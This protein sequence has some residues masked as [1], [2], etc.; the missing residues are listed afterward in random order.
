[1]AIAKTTTFKIVADYGNG[2]VE[3]TETLAKI[4]VYGTGTPSTPSAGEGR[5]GFSK[6]PSIFKAK[7]EVFDLEGTLDRVFNELGDLILDNQVQGIQ[8]LEISVGQVMDYRKLMTAF[9]LIKLP[10]KID[11]TAT[12]TVNEQFIRLEYQGLVKGFQIF[13]GA[14][15]NLLSNRDVKADVLLKLIFEFSSPVQPNGAEISNIKQA[16]NRNPVDR[17]NLT[18]KVTY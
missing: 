6:T 13:Q 11:Q 17:V 5:E 18:A 8:S 12:I 10:L 1:T 14:V 16:L 9:P 2:E 4:L 3:E 7:P 15:S